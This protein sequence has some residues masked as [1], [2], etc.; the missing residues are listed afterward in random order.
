MRAGRWIVMLIA[1]AAVLSPTAA[2]ARGGSGS[3]S[4]HSSGGGGISGGFGYHSYGSSG[5]GG[6]SVAGII[7]LIIII[8]V[9][10]WLF[11]RM[12]K[13][14]KRGLNTVSDHVAHRSDAAAHERAAQIEAQVDELAQTDTTFELEALKARAVS[15]Y[16]TAQKAW[17]GKDLPTLQRILAPAL[18]SKWSEELADYTARGETNVVEVLEGPAVELVNVANREGEANDTVT[19][20]IS[21]TLNDYVRRSGRP[22]ERRTDGSTRPV[23][24]WTLRKTDAGA[25]VVAS[26]EQAA[27]GAHHLTDAIETDGW[28]QKAVARAAVLDV[29]GNTTATGVSDVLSLTTIS[30]TTDADAA[31]GDLSV[32]DG[33]FDKAV[34]EVAIEQFLEEWAMNDGSLDFTAVRTPHRTVLRDAAVTSIQVR[35]LLSREPVVFRVA[36]GAEGLYY[37]VDRRTEEV[38]TGDAHRRRPVSFTFDLRLDGPRAKGWTV[39]AA[40]VQ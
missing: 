31:A 36:V 12:R 27:E 40:S 17:T 6:G 9:A 2:F 30:W 28:D 15:L 4:F 1:A 34:L 21:A 25:W 23:E 11:S 29:A 7:V 8:A 38:L 37:E 19:F 18:Y 26:I 32:V 3:H 33:R 10:W 5:A 35:S 14:A 39:I 20:R 24:F 13:S 22:D 16:Q